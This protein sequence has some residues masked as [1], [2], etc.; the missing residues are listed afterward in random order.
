MSVKDKKSGA[1][2]A[3]V[4]GIFAVLFIICTLVGSAIIS[5]SRFNESYNDTNDMDNAIN[6][7]INIGVYY[8]KCE[9]G[10]KEELNK[11]EKILINVKP[12]YI[13]KFI[14][15]TNTINKFDYLVT[16]EN[17][18]NDTITINAK[19]K[20]ESNTKTKNGQGK[21]KKVVVSES[22]N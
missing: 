4:L 21:I 9:N 11:E 20:N 5:T 19:I 14:S 16:L 15:K 10:I 12:E 1:I 2:L 17:T 13:N 7:A 8:Y 18:S 22:F 6:S 3:W